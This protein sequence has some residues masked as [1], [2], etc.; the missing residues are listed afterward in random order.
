[1]KTINFLFA[2]ITIV[3]FTNCSTKSKIIPW[4]QIGKVQDCEF[5]LGDS[6]KIVCEEYFSSDENGFK[7]VLYKNNFRDYPVYVYH[8]PITYKKT[9]DNSNEY[10]SA[11][12]YF[13]CCYPKNI[14]VLADKTTPYREV[15]DKM[16]TEYLK[17]LEYENNYVKSN[18]IIAK[19]KEKSK[20]IKCFQY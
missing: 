19:H 5:I 9:L 2:L 6:L 20:T 8:M 13:Y 18:L 1:M 11:L 4:S 10:E 16:Q 3:L 17:S 15:I 12:E 14:M 7:Y